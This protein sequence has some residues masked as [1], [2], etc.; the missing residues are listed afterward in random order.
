MDFSEIYS[1]LDS[2]VS[3]HSENKSML[4]FGEGPKTS[5]DECRRVLFLLKEHRDYTI[6]KKSIALAF[7]PLFP[8]IKNHIDQ[9][10]NN[11]KNNEEKLLYLIIKKL[12]P[13]KLFPLNFKVLSQMS[14]CSA[15]VE[16]NSQR[17][18]PAPITA[19]IDGYY[20]FVIPIGGNV[21][22][23]PLIPRDGATPVTLPPSIRFLGSDKERRNAQEFIVNK[24]ARMGRLYQLHA[25]AS[26]LNHSDP[27]LGPLSEFKDAVTSFDL[28]FATALCALAYDDRSKQYILNLVNVLGCYGILDHFIRTIVTSSRLAVA[29]AESDDI[30]EYTALVNMF[31]CS[32]FD[33]IDEINHNLDITIKELIK[34][35]CVEKLHELPALSKYAIRCAL[36][37]ACYQDVSGDTAIATFMEVVVRPF[38][39]KMYL[40][41]PY[42]DEKE[43]MLKH[44]DEVLLSSNL[45]K[46][47][48]VEILGMDIEIGLSPAEVDSD[49]GFL[50]DFAISRVDELVRLIIL[51]N[52]SENENNPIFQ[53]V[54]FA[55]KTSLD[56][57]VEHDRSDD[58]GQ[59]D[60]QEINDFNL[61]HIENN[62]DSIHDSEEYNDYYSD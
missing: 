21:I 40:E 44:S 39:R 38:V 22:R 48:I 28:S 59:I 14:L 7:H 46:K 5:I 53:T 35:L 31:T 15:P 30:P 17:F 10:K 54:I 50:Y 4:Y 58:E 34:I 1:A 42:L 13:G 25:F 47:A 19:F 37:V 41:A 26:V 43:K 18:Q 36:V 51:L 56:N 32:S 61:Q 29:S 20:D 6:F 16:V 33:W 24:A 45:V 8:A 60:E 2:V 12:I 23:I 3:L 52:S 55:Y 62:I 49:I 27:R 11:Y 57:D 9:I